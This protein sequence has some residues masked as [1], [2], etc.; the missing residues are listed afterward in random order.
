MDEG[1][2][3]G[4]MSETDGEPTRRES[5]LLQRMWRGGLVMDTRINNEV[6]GFARGM[7]E[8]LIGV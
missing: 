3:N 5:M 4:S 2:E 1:R 7:S 6:G 8:Q